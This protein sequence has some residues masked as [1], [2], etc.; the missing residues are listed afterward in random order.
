MKTK[1]AIPVSH[2]K[3]QLEGKRCETGAP[4][5]VEQEGGIIV[6]VFRQPECTWGYTITHLGTQTV[7]RR[8]TSKKSQQG[9]FTYHKTSSPLNTS[10]SWGLQNIS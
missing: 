7:L 9:D 4:V 10:L 2:F 6:Q 8:G 1:L 3:E 5:G